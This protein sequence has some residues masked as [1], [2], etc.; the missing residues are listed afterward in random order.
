M[1]HLKTNFPFADFPEIIFKFEVNLHG[2]LSGRINTCKAATCFS[3]FPSFSLKGLH[4]IIGQSH[5]SIFPIFSQYAKWPGCWQASHDMREG[6]S[7]YLRNKLVFSL[8]NIS[9]RSKLGNYPI[10]EIKAPVDGK[11][12]LTLLLH[13]QTVF[14]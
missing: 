1:T 13:L 3:S 11:A 14:S 5:T 8:R 9:L 10:P 6:S 2:A 12:L 7:S 4:A